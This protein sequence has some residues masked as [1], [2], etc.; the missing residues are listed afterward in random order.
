MAAVIFYVARSKFLPQ[1]QAEKFLRWDY[2]YIDRG[3][4]ESYPSL[5]DIDT[6]ATYELGD[7]AIGSSSSISSGT[8]SPTD[9]GQSLWDGDTLAS[10]S[11][12]ELE[13]AAQRYKKLTL[14]QS[15][16]EPLS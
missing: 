10:N 7:W 9:D 12:S 3:E 16:S 2:D 13:V 6:K 1:R 11:D 14:S 15:I 5:K 4:K 8:A